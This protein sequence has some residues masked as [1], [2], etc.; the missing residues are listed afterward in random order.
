MV[1]SALILTTLRDRIEA[2]LMDSSNRSWDT[3]TLDEAIKLALADL[4]QAYGST[5]TVKDL[6]SAASTT[7][8]VLDEN[9]L[10][11]GSQAYAASSRAVN[12]TEK[13]N[14]GQD[15][16]PALAAWARL[17]MQL[18]EDWLAKVTARM[19]HSSSAAPHGQMDWTEEPKDF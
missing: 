6:A 16:A 11:L 13:V 8:D 9:T 14:L 2:G 17:R 3:G 1:A 19:L 4:S 5:L 15:G 7:V 10:V 12:R 18:F